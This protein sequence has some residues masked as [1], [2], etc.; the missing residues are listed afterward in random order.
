MGKVGADRDI[1]S[2]GV[3]HI[4]RVDGVKRDFPGWVRGPF[5]LDWG[6]WLDSEQP[7]VMWVIHHLATG[8]CIC[9]IG[10]PITDVVRAVDLLLV[11]G[12][13]AFDDPAGAR[14]YDDAPSVL[15]DA[16]FGV[17]PADRVRRPVYP[18]R[19]ERVG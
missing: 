6:L 2:P 7:V 4:A 18:D 1:W 9:A 10:S 16:G 14:D 13:W 5:G 19:L 11:M 17:F 3:I 12:D 15:R 8:H